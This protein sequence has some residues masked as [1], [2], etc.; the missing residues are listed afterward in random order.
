[1]P[2]ASNINL[3]HACKAIQ[4]SVSKTGS[5]RGAW[6][7]F[8]TQFTACCNSWHG[9]DIQD[10]TVT[11][12]PIHFVRLYVYCECSVC[13]LV[14][15]PSQS[16]SSSSLDISS[17]LWNIIVFMFNTDILC[18]YVCAFC[19][20][21]HCSKSSATLSYI[22]PANKE[23]T[24]EGVGGGSF[25]EKRRWGGGGR[26]WSQSKEEKSVVPLKTE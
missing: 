13:S 18:V 2:I 7:P 15:A 9:R 16:K 10:P 20:P 5:S 12:C 22:L 4:A 17:F 23:R 11:Y 8:G 19:W 3:T 6:S 25:R 24:G 26:K 21:W 14:P 1:M